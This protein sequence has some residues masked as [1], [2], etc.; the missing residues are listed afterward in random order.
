LDKQIEAFKTELKKDPQVTAAAGGSYPGIAT[1]TY[2]TRAIGVPSAPS[3]SLYNLG[4]DHDYI[5][6]LGFTL[7][8]GRGYP[9]EMAHDTRYIILNESAVR[10]LGISD[11]IGKQ[12]EGGRHPR[13]IVGVLKDF[14]FRSLHNDI[15]PFAMLLIDN[16]ENIS[17]YVSVRIEPG[18][19]SSVLPRI[20]KIWKSF[21]SE[22]PF[23]YSILDERL[24]QWYTS[25]KSTGMV[26]SVFSV[27]AVII[28]CLGLFGLAAFTTEQ[29]T[30]EVGIR[31]VLGASAPR[32]MVFFM[33]DFV[34]LVTLAF[35]FSVPVTYAVMNRWL[36]S[37]SFSADLDVMTFVFA[38]AL[39][40]IVALITVSLQVTK[41]ALSNPVDSLRY[42]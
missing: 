13:T 35:V 7:V 1:H 5:N 12:V 17:N 10:A 32:I 24:A 27:L 16:I 18:S 36:K 23:Q 38:G 3:V 6:T 14:H 41:A 19:L 2:S 21:T 9:K 37:F 20:E 28:G 31:K 40:M 4:G 15:A 39:T 34:I 25:E 33:K 26:S 11:P 42:E 8:S 29:R 30:R 22:L